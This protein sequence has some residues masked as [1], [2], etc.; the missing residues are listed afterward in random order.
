MLV[1]EWQSGHQVWLI[2]IVAR[3]YGSRVGGGSRDDIGARLGDAFCWSASTFVHDTGKEDILQFYGLGLVGAQDWVSTQDA[4]GAGNDLTI[5]GRKDLVDHL[6]ATRVIDPTSDA[7]VK[8]YAK[9]LID[10][11]EKSVTLIA[12]ARNQN[13]AAEFDETGAPRTG[14]GAAGGA[15]LIGANGNDLTP[16]LRAA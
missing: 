7:V 14:G 16:R 10:A 5:V 2:D 4:S 9:P 8:Q 1:G 11:A 13:G 6:I 3:A 12:I 15:L